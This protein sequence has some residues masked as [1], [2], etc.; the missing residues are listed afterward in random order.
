MVR[1]GFAW[2]VFAG[3]LVFLC[4]ALARARAGGVA[5][6]GCGGCHSGGAV[7][8]I[9]M[10]ASP[11]PL[12]PGATATITISF[13]GTVGGIYLRASKGTLTNLA[14]E[15]TKSGGS[16][17][18][19]IHSTPRRG[20]GGTVTFKVGWTAPGTPGGVDFNAFIV[21]GNGDGA[22]RNDGAGIG[23]LTI[24]YGCSGIVYYRDYDSDGFGSM[25]SGYTK[26]CTKP[27]Y[28]S[29]VIGDC[30]DNDERIYPGNKES[31]NGR[32]DNC[33]GKID[34]GL[35]DMATVYPDAD[36]DGHGAQGSAS[37]AMTIA[38]CK[39]PVG[40]GFGTD[41]CDDTKP[42]VYAG[43]KEI[44]D[45]IDNNCNGR[46]DEDARPACGVGWCRRLAAACGTDICTPGAPRAETCNAFDDDCDGINDNGTDLEL[47]GVAGQQCFEGTCVPAGTVPDAGARDAS[48]GP[49]TGAA[50]TTGGGTGAAGTSTNVVTGAAGDTPGERDR[51]AG[52]A[53]G[54]AAS[55]G[56]AAALL[57]AVALV[58]RRRRTTGADRPS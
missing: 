31:C 12:S 14:G 25:L 8:T 10:A 6:D 13:P 42:T 35:G 32:D 56:A 55:S 45:Y 4:P 26:D 19:V 17:T 30:N 5:A 47:C 15:G 52:C 48:T 36:G 2:A 49:V 50:G 44:C 37:K 58:A 29:T 34:E 38:G 39:L 21:A 11:D 51:A 40:Y 41:D 27:M 24:A 20:V 3:L 23:F 57:L 22:A 43:A 1:Q 28:Y 16:A 9:N 53:V 46:V 7:P 33:D 54:G 18:A